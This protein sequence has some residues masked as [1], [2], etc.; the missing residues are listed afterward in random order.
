MDFMIDNSPVYS[1]ALL[2]GSFSCTLHTCESFGN[3]RMKCGTITCA[4]M[5]CGDYFSPIG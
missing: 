5:S 2:K 3:C 4:T 1:L